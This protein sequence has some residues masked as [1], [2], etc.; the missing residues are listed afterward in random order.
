MRVS[1][2][3]EQVL[4][5]PLLKQDENFI[6]KTLENVSLKNKWPDVY[7]LSDIFQNDIKCL[8]ETEVT[9]EIILCIFFR[10]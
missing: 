6:N 4:E 3:N 2:M 5:N 9:I 8:A 7:G 1:A 10:Y